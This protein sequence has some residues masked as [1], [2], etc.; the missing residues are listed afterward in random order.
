MADSNNQSIVSIKILVA[1][2][3]INDEYAIQT[4]RVQSEVNRIAGAQIT[5]V[6]GS[7]AKQDFPISSTDDFKPGQ[8]IEIQA[9]FGLTTTTIFKGIITGM[10][11]NATMRKGPALVVECK[12]KSV[13]MT[14]GAKNATFTDSTDSDVLSTLISNNGLSANVKSTSNTY[15]QIVQYY[16]TDWDFLVARA[17]VNGMIVL[18]EE[19]GVT[20]DVPKVD[21]SPVATFTFGDNI[22]SFNTKMDARTQFAAVQAQAWDYK[23]QAAIS[24]DASDPS[25]PDQGNIAGSDLAAITS[26]STVGLQTTGEVDSSALKTW[27]DSRLLKSR[28]AKIRGE[29]KVEGSADLKPNTIV[30]IDGMGDR[31][32]GS[33][34]VSGVRHEIDSGMWFSTVQI[35]LDPNW[36]AQSHDITAAPT[37][38]LLPGIRGLQNGTVQQIYEDPAGE[39]RVQVNVPMFK[40]STGDGTI[41]ARWV[42]PYATSG[43]GQF[44]MPEVDDEVVLGFLN[45]DPRFPIILGSLYSSQRAPA[46]DPTEENP[47][48]AIVTKSQLT[49]E[50]D[51][52]N[53]VLTLKTP[54]GNQMVFTDQDQG[55]T[56]TDQN[57]NQIQLNSS[58]ITMQ[59]PSDIS[60]TADG[61]VSI[62]GT[63]GVT[64]SSEATATVSA[65][66]SLSLSGLDV[67]I[68]G[69]AS[70]AASGGAE[71]TLSAEG[72][73]SLT[74]AMIM[75]N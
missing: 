36:F 60:I 52:E 46:Y 17:E 62:S 68:S 53:K 23:T 37:S 47:K 63:A 26:P 6:D 39:T 19:N 42:Q 44:F 35:G 33:A 41:W 30:K 54:G 28:L 40:S 72:E 51:D 7:P 11:L 70:L 1:G 12:D 43:A 73:L 58:G 13:K 74:G 4:V 24:S 22:Y 75:I 59:S 69:E 45:E 65:E 29:I 5:V 48:K 21:G 50:F 18:T 32:N 55:I 57:S 14:I 9:G 25:V 61:Q 10:A 15:P 34:F 20:V 8:E 71:A 56:I 16:S 2:S 49:I 3:E 67:S 64:V 66:A 31:F 38:A 27:A